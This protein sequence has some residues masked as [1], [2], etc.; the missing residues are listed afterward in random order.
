VASTRKITIEVPTELL[1]RALEVTGEGI[2]D[3]VRRGLTLIAAGRAYDPLRS[4]RGKV[5]F[6]I[7][8]RALREDR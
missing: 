6:G 4:L 1:E 3:T 7:R 5:H 8:L 2:A